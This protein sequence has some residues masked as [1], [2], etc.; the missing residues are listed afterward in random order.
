MIVTDWQAA[1]RNLAEQLRAGVMLPG[2]ILHPR[3]C[4]C[5]GCK[6]NVDERLRQ[7][8]FPMRIVEDPALPAD[9]IIVTSSAP[10][11][12]DHDQ[13]CP[14]AYRQPTCTCGAIHRASIAIDLDGQ[15]GQ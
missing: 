10:Y 12:V 9:R 2:P 3:H 4:H 7:F 13:Q 6:P 5:D 15:A 1:V 14:M 8:G 11:A